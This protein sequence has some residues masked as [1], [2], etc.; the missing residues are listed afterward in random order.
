MTLDEIKNE[1]PDVRVFDV[2]TGKYSMW[3]LAG[4]SLPFA[5]I[6]DPADYMRSVEVAWET[7]ARHFNTGKPIL[8]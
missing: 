2:F 8:L 6:V 5:R 7:I 4:A 1:M 3:R